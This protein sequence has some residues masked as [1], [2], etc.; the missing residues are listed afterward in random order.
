M[1]KFRSNFQVRI[2]RSSSTQSSGCCVKLLSKQT[3]RDIDRDRDRERERESVCV[4]ESNIPVEYACK[5][6][7]QRK[8]QPNRQNKQTPGDTRLSDIYQWWQ[9]D[10]GARRQG[11]AGRGGVGRDGATG[12]QGMTKWC[13]SFCLCLCLCLCVQLSQMQALCQSFGLLRVLKQWEPRSLNHSD[14]CGRACVLAQLALAL[15]F[16]LLVLLIFFIFVAFVFSLA[17]YMSC[18]NQMHALKLWRCQPYQAA[19]ARF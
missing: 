2:V 4:R 7:A 18:I 5:N 15:A 10:N 17:A 12:P 1:H 19:V 13:K 3:E 6:L 9:K 8:R 14:D 16:L 11:R